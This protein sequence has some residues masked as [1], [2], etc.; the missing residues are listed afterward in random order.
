MESNPLVSIVSIYYNRTFKL[1]ES[2]QSVLNQTYS[3]FEF[4]IIDDCSTDGQTYE[5]LLKFANY[6][7]VHVY[8]N[9][10][11]LGFVTTIRKAFDLAKGDFVAIHGSGDISDENRI[12]QQVNAFLALPPDT[13]VVSSL[14]HYQNRRTGEMYVRS[15]DTGYVTLTTILTDSP[16]IHGSA[17]IRRDY[18]QQVGGYRP[19]FKYRQDRDLWSR[20]SLLGKLYIIDKPLYTLT[21]QDAGV[22]STLKS[23]FTGIFYS[24]LVDDL[25]KQR[26]KNGRDSIDIFGDDAK[27]LLNTQ[28]SSD[29]IYRM[30]I[31]SLLK[32]KL[33]QGR[34]IVA[35]CTE[36]DLRLGM[37]I[38]L[39]LLMRVFESST[40]YKSVQ[41]IIGGLRGIRGK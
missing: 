30:L 5:M 35:F 38:K 16:I 24:L 4:I 36:F 14:C 13:A 6:P 8:Q 19:F 33:E 18:Y 10:R 39:R 15:T 12:V 17:M 41:I 27:F 23:M 1:V 29:R 26:V 31:D 9:E 34:Q 25:I 28:K 22:S 2:I 40:V 32:N 37:P 11:N 3:N 21:V 7:G 20:I